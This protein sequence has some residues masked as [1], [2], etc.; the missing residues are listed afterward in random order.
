[1]KNYI[2]K[3]ILIASFGVWILAIVLY[4]ILFNWIDKSINDILLQM[5][6][7]TLII[8][9]PGLVQWLVSK[10]KA[11]YMDS[12]EMNVPSF[13]VVKHQKLQRKEGLNIEDLARVLPKQ[14]TISNIDSE[15]NKIKLYDKNIWTWATGY[16][17]ELRQNEIVIFSFPFSSHSIGAEGGREKGLAK[18]SACLS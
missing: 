1:M 7:P 17:I 15:N 10:S 4:A 8:F 12:S 16:I 2:R 18:L 6:S 14:F 13:S 3:F 11:E 9:I 5:L